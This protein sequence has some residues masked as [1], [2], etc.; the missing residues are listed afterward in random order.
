MPRR[1]KG[2]VIEEVRFGFSKPQHDFLNA[3]E[4]YVAAVAGFGSGKTHVALSRMYTNMAKAAVFANGDKTKLI[5]QAYLAPTYP[6]I[7]DIFYPAIDKLLPLMGFEPDNDY[8]INQSKHIVEIDGLGKILCRTMERPEKIVGWEVADAVLDEFD[9]LSVDK[10][11]QAFRK[12]SARLRQKNPTGRI[13]QL[14]VTTT[15]EGFKATYKLFKQRPLK[16]SRLIQMS[17]YSNQKHLPDDYI[18]E[19]MEQYPSQLIKAYLMGEFVNLTSGRVYKEYDRVRCRSNERIKE[20]DTL[21]IGQDFNVGKMASTIYVARDN[22][23]HAVDELVDLLD[24]PNLIEVL[25]ERFDKHK[26]VIYPDASGKNRK[27][28]DASKSD[29]AML[30]LAGYN[31]KANKKN[32]FVKDRIL[33]VNQAFSRGLL[34]INDTLAPTVASNLEQQ[35]YD[36]NGEPEKTGDD[37]QND[38]TGY[39]IVYEMPIKKPVI[40]RSGMGSAV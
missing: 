23:W 6:L 30:K 14:F 8:I 13:N 37:H 25:K 36:K 5:D 34:K 4:K 33:S 39:P 21:Y 26:I 27:S 9:I 18:E 1:S 40:L 29:I 15:P 2:N 38:A 32:P 35:P 7:R 24:T 17:T 31:I 16:N 19:L 12:T 10:A 20:G 22:V 11:I 3:K 28:Q